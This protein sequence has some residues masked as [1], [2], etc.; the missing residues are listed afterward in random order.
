MRGDTGSIA[1]WPDT[2]SWK[3]HS[4]VLDEFPGFISL[5][6]RFGECQV[7]AFKPRSSQPILNA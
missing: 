6:D 3:M 7:S 2:G 5:I 1:N 4:E